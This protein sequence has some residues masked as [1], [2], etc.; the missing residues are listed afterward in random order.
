MNKLI[1]YWM[2]SADEDIKTAKVLIDNGRSLPALFFC[3]LAIEKGLKGAFV[4]KR[5]ETPPKTHNLIY[6]TESID[7][8]FT[9]DIL[10]F[11]GI[12]M[13]YQ[14]SGRY[15]D[16]NPLEITSDKV[17]KYYEKTLEILLWIKKQL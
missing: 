7:L 8:S 1:K 11:F 9:N 17:V 14:I 5:E 16:L 4:K 13:N 10:D 3:H 2:D 12:L 15:P 6:L